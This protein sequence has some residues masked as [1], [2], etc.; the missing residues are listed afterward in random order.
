MKGNVRRGDSLRHGMRVGGIRRGL[1]P[2][3]AIF[4]ALGVVGSEV[5]IAAHDGKRRVAVSIERGRV[6]A[7][8]KGRTAEGSGE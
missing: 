1:W 7:S 5:A 8:L 4:G 2:I 6:V 3:I